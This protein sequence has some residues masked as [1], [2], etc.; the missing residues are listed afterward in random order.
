MAKEKEGLIK[1]TAPLMEKEQHGLLKPTTIYDATVVDVEEQSSKEERPS[2]PHADLD[3][4]YCQRLCD[5]MVG[6]WYFGFVAFGDTSSQVAIL[7]E[8]IVYKRRWV[9]ADTFMELYGLSAALPGPS[10]THL[11]IAAAMTRAGAFGGFVAL[12]IWVAPS[13]VLMIVCGLFARAVTDGDLNEVIPF[14]ALLLQGIGPASA[15]LVFKA[16][17]RFSFGLDRFG[18]GIAATACAGSILLNGDY[19]LSASGDADFA[20]P[21][22]IALGGLL[23]LL[24]FTLGHFLHKGTLGTYVDSSPA[25]V[26]LR[27]RIGLPVWAGGIVLQFY[28]IVLLAAVLGAQALG[29]TSPLRPPLLLFESFFRMG[30][31]IFGGGEDVLAMLESEMVPAFINQTQFFDGLGIAQALPGP[32]FCFAAYIGA[33]SDGVTGGLVAAVGIFAPAYFFMITGMAFWSKLHTLFWFKAILKGVSAVSVGF[34]AYAAI[35]LFEASVEKA[36]D[37]IVFVLAGCL[38]GY[39]DISAPLVVLAAVIVGAILNADAVSLA[40]MP[41]NTS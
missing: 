19:H 22:M 5:V 4:S 16:A 38:S 36:A 35:Y 10:A 11:I 7:Q 27:Q 17:G 23:T 12:V 9:D 41:Y 40:Q 24:D 6:T 26:S 39:Y 30:S 8:E 25:D 1:P 21:L 32:L 37:A 3:T 2:S 33:F 31:L 28:V 15:A 20:F 29:V 13:C 34:M 14:A 18:F